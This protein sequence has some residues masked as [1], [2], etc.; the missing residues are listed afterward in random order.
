M[1]VQTLEECD[2]PEEYLTD[3]GIK[4]IGGEKVRL[5]KCQLCGKT[6]KKWIDQHQDKR[7]ERKRKRRGESHYW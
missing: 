7:T 5:F 2:H 4:P 3:M 1:S 6:I